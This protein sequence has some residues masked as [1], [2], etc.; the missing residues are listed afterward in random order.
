MVSFILWCPYF[1]PLVKQWQTLQKETITLSVLYMGHKQ[2]LFLYGE[3]KHIDTKLIYLFFSWFSV[4]INWYMYIN[5]PR[6]TD[7]SNIQYIFKALPCD[8]FLLKYEWDWHFFVDTTFY[9][10]WALQFSDLVGVCKCG[11]YM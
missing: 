3:E 1:S 10:Y 6:E 7:N 11:K 9:N 2:I 5:T 4:N 8:T